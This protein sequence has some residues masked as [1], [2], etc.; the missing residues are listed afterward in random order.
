MQRNSLPAP[1]IV[2]SAPVLGEKPSSEYKEQSRIGTFLYKMIRREDAF[3]KMGDEA[4]PSQR[5]QIYHYRLNLETQA[6][7]QMLIY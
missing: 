5:L 3:E 4:K 7:Q 6:T 1:I 2:F